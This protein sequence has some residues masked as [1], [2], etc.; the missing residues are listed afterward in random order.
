[1]DGVFAYLRSA[2][3][4]AMGEESVALPESI[5]TSIL[6]RQ[7]IVPFHPSHPTP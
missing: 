1:M 4:G 2:D 3:A 7:A 6:K 5:Q